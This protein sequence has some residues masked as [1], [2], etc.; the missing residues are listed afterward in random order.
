MPR[1]VLSRVTFGYGVVFPD[2]D[3]TLES[4]EWSPEMVMDRR[5][6]DRQDGVRRSL[7]LTS[8]ILARETRAP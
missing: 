1:E 3:F 7:G 8:L 2:C 4:V 6:L 5:R